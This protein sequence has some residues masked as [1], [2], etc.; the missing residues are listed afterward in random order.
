MLA[1]VDWDLILEVIGVSFVAGVSVMIV[2]SLVVYGTSRMNEARVNG[3]NPAAFGALA[4]AGTIVFA[5]IIVFAV[6]SI[7]NK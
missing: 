1:V 5:G 4:V 3:T 2:F 7:L 6:L